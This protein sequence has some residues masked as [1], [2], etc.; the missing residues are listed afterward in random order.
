M[1]LYRIRQNFKRPVLD[2]VS[3]R[4][5][6]EFDALKLAERL[7][8]VRRVGITVGS[9]GIRDILKV[10][11]AL[12]FKVRECG[13]EPLLLAAMGSHGGGTETGQREIL[14]SLGVTEEAL[15][16]QLLTCSECAEVGETDG[17][18]KA[19]ALKSALSVDSIIAVNRVKIHTSFH[20]DV[21]SG[22][23]KMLTVGL[24]GPKGAAHFHS[25]G[26]DEMPRFLIGISSLLLQRLPVA[27][28]FAVVENAYEE[29]ALVKGVPAESLLAEEAGILR[30]ARSLMPALP[31][32]DL[33]A[34]I[35]E[36]IGKN[37][38]GTGLD[39]NIVGR[40][41]IEG[42]PEPESPSIK[43]I[44]VLDLS[45]ESHGNAT[46]IGLADLTTKKLV[47]NIDRSATYLNC[48]TSGFL[49]RAAI[50]LYAD[51][52]TEMIDFMFRSLGGK[53]AQDVR[54]IQIPNTLHLS[55]CFVSE[56]LM[57]EV[58]LLP[59]TEITDGPFPLDFDETGRL[60][61]RIGR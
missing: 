52:E 17:G 51:T 37:Y 16:V 10:L 53:A 20:G 12:I 27:A 11:S 49:T 29:T 22:L 34:L 3:Q 30:Y 2:D 43:R 61:F 23:A 55:E 56:A 36:E 31:I 59:D 38:S 60:L 58:R 19:Y 6:D 47:D 21:E 57:P 48:L 13:C 15:G 5:S 41:R 24:G 45:P 8:G 39:T 9:R 46:G 7:S 14:E 35:I 25:M 50:P 1:N 18:M 42:T 28:G 54:L 4:T 32:S 33:D 26:R 40:L 44:A